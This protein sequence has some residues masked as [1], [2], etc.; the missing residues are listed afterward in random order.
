MN[1][2]FAKLGNGKCEGCLKFKEQCTATVGS[3]LTCESCEV[4]QTHLQK[5]KEARNP[6]KKDKGE[7]KDGLFGSIVKH[8]SL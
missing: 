4:Q 3:E 5:N 6:Y 7:S 1:I 8:F 2:S